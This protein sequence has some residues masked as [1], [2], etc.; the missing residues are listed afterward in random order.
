M[1]R[2]RTVA[3]Q[4]ANA[5]LCGANQCLLKRDRARQSLAGRPRPPAAGQERI[6]AAMSHEIRTPMTHHRA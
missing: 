2:E 4:S 6:L 5:E 3:V 1:V